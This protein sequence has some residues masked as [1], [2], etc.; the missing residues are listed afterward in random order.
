MVSLFDLRDTILAIR[1]D[2][3]NVYSYA[4]HP[5]VTKLILQV[6]DYL[7]DI[8]VNLDPNFMKGAK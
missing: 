8:A 2:S 5:E 3:K 4:M 6:Q 1:R 7:L